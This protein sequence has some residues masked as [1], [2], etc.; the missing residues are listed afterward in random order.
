LP[1]DPPPDPLPPGTYPIIGPELATDSVVQPIAR[2]MGL[3]MLGTLHERIGDT[4]TPQNAGSDDDDWGRSSWAR[5]LGQQISNHYESF[6]DPR[7]DGQMIGAQIGLDIWRGS[8]IPDHRD[9]AGVYF[10]YSNSNLDVEGLV[11]DLASDDYIRTRTGQVNLDA[12]AGGGYWTHYGPSGWYLDA[13]FQGTSYR[14]DATTQF[15][16]LP[17]AGSGY[18]TSLEGGYPIPMSFGPQF[19]LEPQMQVIWQRV[20]FGQAYDGLGPVDLDLTTGTTGRLGLRGQWTIVSDNGQIWQPYVRANLWHDWGGRAM[21]TFGD[22]QVPLYEEATR[23]E[24]A[25]G[26]TAK[27]RA[28]LSLYALL[29]YQLAVGD[30]DGGRR[31]GVQGDLGLRYT[32]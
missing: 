6:A 11:T 30:T 24:F 8:F 28:E 1:V 20:S 14:G 13:V 5:V 29:G 15:A 21:T 19:V 16:H 26:I 22:D 9:A 7:A 31:Q 25:G 3:A 4:L 12:Y 2:Q 27:I 32:W 18:L 17:I 23:M 10:A